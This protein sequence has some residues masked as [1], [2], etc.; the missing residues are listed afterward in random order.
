LEVNGND[1][2][3]YLSDQ[4]D[5]IECFNDENKRLFILEVTLH[6]ADIS[7]PIKPFDVGYAWAE[8]IAEEFFQQG[9]REKREGLEVSPTMD[10]DVINLANMQLGFLEFVVAPLFSGTFLYYRPY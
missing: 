5:C 8:L 3:S 4:K 2:R 1:I 10:R 9:D 6:C 7:N